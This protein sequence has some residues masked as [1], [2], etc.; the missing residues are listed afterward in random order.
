[1]EGPL[2]TVPDAGLRLVGRR[3]VEVMCLITLTIVG[4]RSSI[5]W[6]LALIKASKR[7]AA[8]MTADGASLMSSKELIKG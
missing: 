8:S 4:E 3:F 2:P 5:H 6:A 7:K 1:M